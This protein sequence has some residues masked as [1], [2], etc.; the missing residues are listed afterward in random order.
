[1]RIFLLASAMAGAACGLAG[2]LDWQGTYDSAARRDCRDLLDA[3]D[4]RNCLTEVE[5]NSSER[6]AERRD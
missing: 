3:H 5:R 1:M 2:C 6:R 4:R